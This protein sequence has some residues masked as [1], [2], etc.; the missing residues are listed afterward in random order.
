[1]PDNTTWIDSLSTVDRLEKL[2]ALVRYHWP[3]DVLKIVWEQLQKEILN[4]EAAQVYEGTIVE[5]QAAL[6]AQQ[7][8]IAVLHLALGHV[9]SALSQLNKV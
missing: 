6:Q 4:C 1:M 2:D 8:R 7:D 3:T 5:V 9:A